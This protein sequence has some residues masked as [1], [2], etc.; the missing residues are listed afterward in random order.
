[1]RKKKL[2]L[3][4]GDVVPKGSVHVRCD[5]RRDERGVFSFAIYCN[6]RLYIGGFSCFLFLFCR[7]RSLGR[8]AMKR[9]R[10]SFVA[11]IISISIYIFL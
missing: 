10:R 9:K 5:W 2:R 11:G 7:A 3:R 8:G 4:N 1:M 6:F